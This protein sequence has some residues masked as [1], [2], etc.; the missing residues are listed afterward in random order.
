[1]ETTSEDDFRLCALRTRRELEEFSTALWS[2]FTGVPTSEVW[3]TQV[4]ARLHLVLG[5]VGAL[6]VKEA[7]IVVRAAV[8]VYRET[9]DVLH[10]RMRGA[11]MAGVRIAEWRNA[12]QGYALLLA[13]ADRA[14]E[15]SSAADESCEHH[16][17][18][19]SL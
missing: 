10:G 15:R 12:V 5:R 1:M 14:V 8:I 3:V 4:S 17:A 2:E 7:L 6:S 11:H 13:D 16:C 18:A 9:S 19:E